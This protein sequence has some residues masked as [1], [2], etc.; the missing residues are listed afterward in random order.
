MGSTH[1]D[2][3][4]PST[5]TITPQVRTQRTPTSSQSRNEHFTKRSSGQGKS[6]HSSQHGKSKYAKKQSSRPKQ[7]VVVRRAPA[8]EYIS[9]C[10]SL[11]SRKPVAGLRVSVQNPETKKSKEQPMGLGK[12]RCSGC[13]K[14][15]KVTPRK[16]APPTATTSGAPNGTAVVKAEVVL[17]AIL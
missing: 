5:T 14:S 1:Q 3:S 11:P 4:L 8:L 9:A 17:A 6:S 2:A 16:P 12:W 7:P 10:C 13:G 15:C